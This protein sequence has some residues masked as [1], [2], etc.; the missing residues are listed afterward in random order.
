MDFS[1]VEIPLPS[2]SLVR[3][4]TSPNLSAKSSLHK[5]AEC[6]PVT[7]S[8]CFDIDCEFV[9]IL[10]TVSVG[11]RG[12]GRPRKYSPPESTKV[13]V[14]EHFNSPDC[15]LDFL[16]E[17]QESEKIAQ[18][19]QFE[20]N[21]FGEDVNEDQDQGETERDDCG[22]SLVVST[23]EDLQLF[24]FEDLCKIVKSFGNDSR[25]SAPLQE[26]FYLKRHL[27][28]DNAGDLDYAFLRKRTRNFSIGSI[29]SIDESLQK[30]ESDESG[31]IELLGNCLTFFEC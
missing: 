24:S 10:P 26:D 5:L 4:S 1:A 2:P 22:E 7:V 11:K 28:T 16:L 25:P 30:G 8:S 19:F 13:F 6:S 31:N 21:E 17:Q 9:P 14:T 29:G 20:F 12:P 3:S 27:F 18:T 15:S 23:L